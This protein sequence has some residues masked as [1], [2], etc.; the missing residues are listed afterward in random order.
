MPEK[1][2]KHREGTIILQED[3]P[4]KMEVEIN[5]ISSS[6]D[7]SK[8]PVFIYYQW[9]KKCGTCVHFCPTGVLARK[10]DG[11]PYVKHPEKCVHCE[12]CDR[13]CPDFAITGAKR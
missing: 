10:A 5:E 12:T 9:C 1:L 2:E 4:E 13:L 6:G 7:Y 3:S 11:A 8:S